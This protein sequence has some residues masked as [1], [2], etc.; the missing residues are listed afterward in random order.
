[1]KFAAVIVTLVCCCLM[2]VVRRQTKAAL[3]VMGAMTLTLVSVPGI[4]LHKANFLLPMAF[5]L[6]ECKNLPQYIRKLRCMPYVSY[7]LLIVSGS[8]LLAALTSPYTGIIET[9]QS[10]LLFQYFALAYAFWAI[11]D[12]KSFKPILRISLYCMIA[13]TIFG[14]LNYFDQSAIFVNALTNGKTSNLYEDVALG[15][16]YAVSDR[17]RVQSMFKSAFDYGYI[18][19]VILILHLHGW[20][21]HLESKQAFILTLICCSFGIITCACRIVWVGAILSIACYQMWAFRPNKSLTYGTIAMIL[22]FISYITIPA[23]EEKVNNVTD[24]FVEDSETGGSSIQLRISQYMYVL[25][26]TEG[27]EL[28]GLGKGYWS[29]TF[30]ED[31][32]SVS[33]LQGVESVILGYLLE[34]GII[35]LVLWAIFYTIVFLYLWRNRENNLG[36]TGLGISVFTLYMIFSIGTGELGSVY[37]TMLLLGFVIKAIESAKI[38]ER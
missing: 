13:L 4:P 24:I 37:P 36:L 7:L 19:A 34:R 32:Y 35:G 2:F 23:V 14:L 25:Y 15:D 38:K 26:Y 18:C 9:V 5:L 16:V 33:G 31:P 17:F 11:T 1:M 10:E 29:H 30:A 12:E 3:L 21:R 6:S 28:L 22:M 20:Y 8:A 27:N